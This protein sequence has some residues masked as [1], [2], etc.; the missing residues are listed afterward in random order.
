MSKKTL[1]SLL[2]SIPIAAASFL[3]INKADGQ[4]M[5]KNNIKRG[6]SNYTESTKIQKPNTLYAGVQLGRLPLQGFSVGYGRKI[7]SKWETYLFLSKGKY[8]SQFNSYLDDF[9]SHVDYFNISLG[10]M[11][12][13]KKDKTGSKAFV[14]FG[15]SYNFLDK[16]HYIPGTI[17]EKA[18]RKLS[19]EGGAGA[20]FAKGFGTGFLF[21]SNIE[22]KVYIRYSF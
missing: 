12:H 16:K 2:Y 13:T 14:A 3:P 1:K 8:K 9:N 5:N 17:N 18:F 6:F 15:A 7:T 10:G 20:I 4:V 21:N 22:S 19:L 11:R